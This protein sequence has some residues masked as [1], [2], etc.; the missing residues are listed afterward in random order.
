MVYTS[1]VIEI[2]E[3]LEFSAWLE[4]LRDA[5]ARTR[6]QARILRLRYGNPG[7]V[8]PVGEGVSEM[9]IDYG[10]GY[11]VYFVKR[12][13]L[14]IILLAGGAK[15]TQDKDIKTALKLARML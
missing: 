9:R 12:G 14:L 4:S 8:K 2:R 15:P 13:A 5:Q 10:P 3:T 7:D 6:V 1:P 11:R